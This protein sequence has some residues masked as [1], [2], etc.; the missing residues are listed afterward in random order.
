MTT[1]TI[2]IEVD[3]ETARAFRAADD[4]K[5]KRWSLLL[6]L[7]LRAMLSPKQRTLLQVM[8]DMS[9][10]AQQNGL[11]PEILESILNDPE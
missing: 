5:R 8:D 3:Q 1:E 9:A 2:S 10:Q 4:D 11:T 7:R 6:E